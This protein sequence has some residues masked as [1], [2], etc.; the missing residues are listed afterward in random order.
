MIK[1]LLKRNRLEEELKQAQAAVSDHAEALEIVR[2]RLADY[3]QIRLHQEAVLS[4]IGHILKAVGDKEDPGVALIASV[5]T[6]SG[7]FLYFAHGALSYEVANDA[8][9]LLTSFVLNDTL[10]KRGKLSPMRSFRTGKK[11]TGGNKAYDRGG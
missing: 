1:K 6:E 10:A 3:E 5:I 8:A 9:S 4:A 11:F 7:E 2:G